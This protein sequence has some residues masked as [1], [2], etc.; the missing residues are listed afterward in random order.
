MYLR[1]S[2]KELNLLFIYQICLTSYSAKIEVMTPQSG[3][4]TREGGIGEKNNDVMM[5]T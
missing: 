1:S 4:E 2:A 5:K 3:R